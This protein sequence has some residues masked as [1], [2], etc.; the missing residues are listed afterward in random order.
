MYALRV[1]AAI[2]LALLIQI[3]IPTLTGSRR[4]DHVD[5]PLIV[6]V[7]LSLRRS[8]L[9]GMVTGMASGLVQDA[10]VHSFMGVAGLT[11]TI[12][13]YFVSTMSMR[14]ELDNFLTRLG[15]MAVAAACNTLFFMEINKILRVPQYAEIPNRMMWKTVGIDTAVNVGVA[16]IIFVLLDRLVGRPDPGRVETVRTKYYR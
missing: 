14:F 6:T 5:L 10:L 13:G 9:L 8:Q 4:F 2:V 1:I 7:Y 15:V 16:L 11:K 12:I 3:G